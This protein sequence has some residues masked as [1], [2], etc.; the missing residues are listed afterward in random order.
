MK[1]EKIMELSEK[2]LNYLKSTG[3]PAS[4]NQNFLLTD[5]NKVLYSAT[6]DNNEYYNNQK[7][8]N[9]LIE[10]INIWKNEENYEKLYILANKQNYPI[11]QKDSKE[12]SAQIILP[13]Y[14]KSELQGFAIF[15]RYNGYFIESSMK[16]PTTI[17]NWIMTH[18]Q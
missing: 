9:Y 2:L 15:F 14:L 7:L 4:I 6:F 8:S 17:R 13:I 18:L 5:L 11:I 12:Y 3:I 16:A 1:G 10:L